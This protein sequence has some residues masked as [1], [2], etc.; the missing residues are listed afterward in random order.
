MDERVEVRRRVRN[1]SGLILIDVRES[2]ITPVVAFNAAG[3]KHNLV[4]SPQLLDQVIQNTE[5]LDEDEI[6]NWTVL[7]NSFNMPAGSKTGYFALRPE[8]HKTLQTELFEGAKMENILSSSSS[9]LAETLPDLLTFNSSIVD[10]MQ[11]ERVAGVELTEETV[12]AECDLFSIVNEFFCNAIIPSITGA[13]FPESYQLLASDLATFNQFF[14]PFA[15]GLPR[16]FPLPG[17]PGAMSARRRLLNNFERLFDELTNPPQKKVPDDDES[18]SGEETDADTPT[19]FTALNE[20]F[21]KHDVPLQARAA[22]ALYLLHSIHSKIVPLA[23]WTLLHLHHHSASSKSETIIASIVQETKTWAEAVQPPSIHPDFPAPPELRFLDASKAASPTSFP[24]LRSCINESRRLYK[25]SVSILRLAK[26]IT[27]TETES[28]RPGTPDQW[29]LEAGSYMDIG[30]SQALAN[31]SSANFLTPNVYQ[32]DRFLHSPAPA[33]VTSETSPY[34]KLTTA[35][36]LAFVAGTLQLWDISAAPKKTFR[37][38]MNEGTAA[39][40]GEEPPKASQER[41]TW[42]VPRAGDGS[43]VKVPKGEVRVRIRRR[44]GLPERNVVR[45]GRM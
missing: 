6:T 2:S 18:L 24:L 14:Y 22:I 41:G 26:P 11:W 9:T 34:E 17:L 21:T 33:S 29:E 25:S 35:L 43:T 27:L 38:L 5:S 8:I 40:Q 1:V 19:P 12:E 15:L 13:A 16:L 7:R 45:K 37:D 42:V 3:A 28:L 30:L 23:C 31:T 10:Q 36:L 4:F 20:L 39:A 44:E 32:P